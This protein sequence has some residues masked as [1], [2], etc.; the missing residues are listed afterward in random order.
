VADLACAI[1]S[2]RDDLTPLWFGNAILRGP[3]LYVLAEGGRGFP[4]RI[5]A[6]QQR[7]GVGDDE[8]DLS[9]IV[10]PVN[11]H[12]AEDISHIL[13]AADLLREP[14]KLVVF[15]TLA[16]SMVG[17]DENSAQDIGLVIDRGGRI[18]R[19]LGASV[20]FVHHAKKDSDVERGSTALRGAVDTL[21]LV[22]EDDESGRVLSCEKQKDADPF[23]PMTFYLTPVGDSCVV[24]AQPPAGIRTLTPTQRAA[25]KVLA[26]L[27]HNGATSTEWLRA[28]GIAE[29][30]FYRVRQWAVREGYVSENTRGNSQRFTLTPSGHHAHNGVGTWVT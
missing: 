5:A 21:C 24:S 16:R 2:R 26:E 11:L 12:N 20:H 6:W 18:V 14:P 7:Y 13:R 3:V 22:R 9:C 27:F 4:R 19:E 15:D 29:R 10:E 30:T 1:A 8:L 28:S 23:D 25:L 17:G